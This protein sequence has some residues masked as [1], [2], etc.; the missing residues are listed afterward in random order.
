MEY[1]LPYN[2][3]AIM[4]FIL[5]ILTLTIFQHLE[6]FGQD[7]CMTEPYFYDTEFFP[8][9]PGLMDRSSSFHLYEDLVVYNEDSIYISSR[10]EKQIKNKLELLHEYGCLIDF[11]DFSDIASSEIISIKLEEKLNNQ[12]DEF[13]F[14][15]IT[16]CG[17]V[18]YM[19]ISSVGIYIFQNAEFRIGVTVPLLYNPDV[20]NEKVAVIDTSTTLNI[21]SP[22]PVEIVTEE[23]LVKDEHIEYE[24]TPTTFKEE[25]RVLYSEFSTCPEAIIDTVQ[26]NYFYKLPY[27]SLSKTQTEFRIVTEQVLLHDDVI[28]PSY[29]L[30]QPY[31]AYDLSNLTD[32][33]ILIDSISSDCSDSYFM[34][35]IHFSEHLD[36]LAINNP[37]DHIYPPC[38]DGYIPAGAYCYSLG[39][40]SP[41]VYEERY[42]ERLVEPAEL[43]T[44]RTEPDIR[45]HPVT[46]L[47]N[48]DDLDS[49]CIQVNR[50]TIS[51]IVVDKPASAEAITIDAIYGTRQYNKLIGPELAE[52][53]V[54]GTGEDEIVFLAYSEGVFI[55]RTTTE[56]KLEYLHRCT[57][58]TIIDKLV[59]LGYLN[60]SNNVTTEEFY[61]AA[62][63]FQIDKDISIGIIGYSFLEKLGLR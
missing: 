1:S 9:D 40:N 27:D 7:L 45:T 57:R 48:R 19:I 34:N 4:R 8:R 11:D 58:L 12:I 41:A 37:I 52:F 32:K 6:I 60:D 28:G 21:I 44:I 54:D 10:Q 17:K 26:A 24:I 63:C 42:Y 35:C 53:T 23:V 46:E 16:D 59:E 30:R 61:R 14:L 36:S 22:L 29:Y 47:I 20:F 38:A 15:T 2:C 43:I 62:I 51:V 25:I 55:N 33:E 50:D 49:T 13:Q 31:E 3:S 56:D 39:P 5:L 18:T